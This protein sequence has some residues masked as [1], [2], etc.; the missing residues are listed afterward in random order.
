MVRNKGLNSPVVYGKIPWR[1]KWQCTPIF[2]PGESYGPEESGGLW[3]IGS[4][5]GGHD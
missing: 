5:R 3:S 4:Q 1:K 2:L